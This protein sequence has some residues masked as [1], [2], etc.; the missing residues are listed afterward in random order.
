MP[1]LGG[2]FLSRTLDFFYICRSSMGKIHLYLDANMITDEISKTEN[3]KVTVSEYTYYYGG[4]IDWD[5]LFGL[6]EPYEYKYY[7][8]PPEETSTPETQ[9][10]DPPNSRP[11]SKTQPVP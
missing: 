10:K 7:E 1:P 6:F 8:Y 3:S 4:N 9:P 11:T 2:I 5:Y